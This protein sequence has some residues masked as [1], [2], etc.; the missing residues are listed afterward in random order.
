MDD[1]FLELLGERIRVRTGDPRI[2]AGVLDAAPLLVCSPTS[3]APDLSFTLRPICAADRLPD[4][5]SYERRAESVQRDFALHGRGDERWVV[6]GGKSAASYDLETGR[7]EGFVHPDHLADT[8]TIG[9][10][11]FFI[12]LLEWMRRRGR[13]PLHGSCFLAADGCGV[14]V[15]GASGVGKSTATLAAI[16]AGC[17]FVADDTLFAAR[18][19][20]EIR[21]DPFPEPVK[22]GPKS[23]AFFPEWEGRLARKGHKFVLS[24]ELIPSPGRLSD[25]RPDLLLFPEIRAIDRSRFESLSPHEAMVR[26]LPQSVLPADRLQME[27]HIAVLEALVGQARGYLLLFGR[28]LRELPARIEELI[29]SPAS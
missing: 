28:D 24:E 17:P 3:E 26:L 1:L 19:D 18:R 2:R 23:A 25:V 9:H 8:W 6:V 11:L 5:S 27:D 29:A 20:G 10:R 12:P 14:V 13:F 4:F 15:S 16:A 22:V 21:L 7:V